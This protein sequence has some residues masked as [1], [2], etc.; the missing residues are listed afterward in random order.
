MVW[1]AHL[2]QCS[3]L[4]NSKALNLDPCILWLHAKDNKGSTE[5]TNTEHDRRTILK[6]T[7]LPWDGLLTNLDGNGLSY[8][9]CNPA[10]YH[11]T[12]KKEGRGAGNP[13]QSS[14]IPKLPI[15]CP[16]RVQEVNLRDPR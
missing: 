2:L 11:T 13:I 14:K 12:Y 7:E 3:A 6:T 1:Q 9:K 5:L 15:C 8:F 4:P 10:T 16:F